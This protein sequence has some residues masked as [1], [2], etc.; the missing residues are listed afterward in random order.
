MSIDV[1]YISPDYFKTL[2]VPLASG[3]VSISGH[4]RQSPVVI[5]NEKMAQYFFPGQDPI[6]K[7]NRP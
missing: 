1:A 6:G 7:Q 4:S 3:R 5:I 2:D